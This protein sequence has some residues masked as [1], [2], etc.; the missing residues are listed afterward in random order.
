MNTMEETRAQS[1]TLIVTDCELLKPQNASL[2]EKTIENIKTIVESYNL[3]QKI[4]HCYQILQFKKL[5]RILLI[6][7]TVHLTKI[8]HDYFQELKIKIWFA[9]R[10]NSLDSCDS[11]DQC[12]RRE[13]SADETKYLSASSD[14]NSPIDDRYPGQSVFQNTQLQVPDAPI[15]MQSPPASPYEGWIER[16]EEPPSDTTIGYHPKLLSHLLYTHGEEED[17]VKKVFSRTNSMLD[18]DSFDL[19]EGE[20]EKVEARP[21]KIPASDPSISN[22]YPKL[23]IPIVVVDNLEAENIKKYA[24]EFEDKTTH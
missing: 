5:K 3:E 15:Q 6:F 13:I 21:N 11:P 2:L 8:V 24:L 4:H 1:N 23:K 19:G 14:D 17:S 20:D 9:R 12:R 7:S 16:P 10:S 22:D 18:L